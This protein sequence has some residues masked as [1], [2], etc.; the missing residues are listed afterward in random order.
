MSAPLT[1]YVMRHGEVYNP[2]AILYGRLP[3][4]GL[5]DNGREQARATADYLRDKPLDALYSSPMQRA[6]ETA[7]IIA[8]HQQVKVAVDERLN[9]VHT[10][11]DGTSLEALEATLFDL[12]TGNEAPYERPEIV[13]ARVVNFLQ[14]KRRTHGSGHVGLVTHG[15]IVVTLFMWAMGQDASDIGRGRLEDLGLPVPYPVTASVS[16]LTFTT[17][18]SDEIPRYTY[19]CPY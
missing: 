1:F 6:Q 11:Y 7:G 4:Y 18:A 2:Q 3:G 14:E 12:Y 8:Q 13:R 9:E 10:P 16:T 19:Y 5:S 17:Q 15:D